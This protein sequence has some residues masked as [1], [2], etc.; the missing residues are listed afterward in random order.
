[1]GI[2]DGREADD[3]ATAVMCRTSVIIGRADLVVPGNAVHHLVV[4]GSLEI[5]AP[6]RSTANDSADSPDSFNAGCRRAVVYACI[7][8]PELSEDSACC[9][10]SFHRAFSEAVADS[11]GRSF[12]LTADKPGCTVLISGF[13]LSVYIAIL[14]HAVRTAQTAA[15]SA[16]TI[17]TGLINAGSDDTD[18]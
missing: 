5:G 4:Y 2:V 18:T 14:Y 7:R 1:M 6:A 11:Y 12:I 10:F 13:N 9:E 8:S 16:D 17:S 15:D 3:G